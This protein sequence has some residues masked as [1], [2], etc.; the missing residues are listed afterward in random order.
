MAPSLICTITGARSSF[1]GLDDGLHH[2]Q[3]VGVEGADGVAAGACLLQYLLAGDQ[4]HKLLLQTTR[5]RDP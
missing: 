2:L 5:K 1:G 4:G 3:V